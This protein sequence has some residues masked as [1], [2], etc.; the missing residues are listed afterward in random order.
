[1][2]QRLLIAVAAIVVLAGAAGCRAADVPVAVAP[3]S[4]DTVQPTDTA[5]AQLDDLVVTL[6]PVAKGFSA[7]LWL[8]H[9][10]DGSGRLF[11]V[12][13]GGTVRIISGGAVVKRPYLDI[14]R[15]VSSGGERG[16][17]GL[18]FAPDFETSGR[19]FVNYTDTEG[20]TVVAAFTADDPASSAP[21]LDGPIPLLKV[22][23]PYANHNGG[24]IMFGPD[25][26]LWIGMGDGGSGGD[27]Q[28]N[29]QNPRTLLGKMLT[30]T[31]ATQTP[32]ATSKKPWGAPQIVANGLRNPWRFSFD[33]ETGDLWIGDVGQNEWEEIDVVL[34]A[35]LSS[36]PNFGWNRW[37][38]THPFRGGDAGDRASMKF[39]VIQYDHDEG[40]SVTGGY[41]YR[42]SRH[43]AMR[44]TYL[45]ADYSTGWIAGTRLPAA[46]AAADDGTLDYRVL[47]TEAGN[48]ASFGEDESGELYVV[49]LGGTISRVNGT[50][51]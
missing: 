1:M 46:G 47:V 28:G 38:G 4:S 20:D 45:F 18:A 22:E 43:P 24:C 7:P 21:A 50:A 49:D 12:E 2:N 15:L 44:G 33:R 32:Q 41:V 40:Q 16:L 51:K 48:P 39:P 3:G 23:Q 37:E 34:H 27:P 13:Q 42:G 9:A 31:I 29:G 35:D 30:V 8:T 6:E 26:R 17:L 14:S 36:S 10:G 25:G 19:L 11:V 5:P